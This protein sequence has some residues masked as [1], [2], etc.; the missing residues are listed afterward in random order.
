M[1]VSDQNGSSVYCR[2]HGNGGP[3][4]LI[5][6]LGGSGADWALQIPA[7]EHRFRVI[8]PDPPGCG[9][10]SAPPRGFSIAGFAQTMWSLLDKLQ[11]SRLNIVGFSM[12]NRTLAARSGRPSRPKELRTGVARR[13]RE[14]ARPRICPMGTRRH[15]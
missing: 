5:H 6:G 11:M 3:V 1:R 2:L 7:L 9:S 13:C 14:A 4:L 10:S 8:V 12:E 15:L